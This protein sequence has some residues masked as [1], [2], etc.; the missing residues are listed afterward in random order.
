MQAW[1]VFLAV[2]VRE[3]LTALRCVAVTSLYRN[4]NKDFGDAPLRALEIT[5]DMKGSRSPSAKNSRSTT[6]LPDIPISA[7]LRRSVFF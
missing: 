2:S 5:K 1:N 7:A 4:G 3:T 6:K